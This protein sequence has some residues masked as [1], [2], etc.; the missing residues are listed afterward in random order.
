[1]SQHRPFFLAPAFSRALLLLVALAL[2]IPPLA[3]AQVIDLLPRISA[4]PQNATIGRGA[5]VRF[6]VSTLFSSGGPVSYQWYE[7]NTL[8]PG[9][10]AS[11]LDLSNVQNGATY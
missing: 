5:N 8:L 7:G 4:Q 2:L 3:S 10:T 11:T 9:K 1:M 6:S